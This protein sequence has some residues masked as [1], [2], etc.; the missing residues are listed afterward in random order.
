VGGE[1]GGK[2]GATYILVGTLDTIRGG[3]VPASHQNKK[4]G[5]ARPSK[6]SHPKEPGT[7]LQKPRT[8]NG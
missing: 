6:R 8:K 7:Y 5:N 3:W 2:N 1:C 4:K